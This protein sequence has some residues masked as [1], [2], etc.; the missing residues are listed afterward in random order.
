MNGSVLK[1]LTSRPAGAIP[2]NTEGDGIDDLGDF[3]WLRGIRDRALMLS[4][5]KKDGS[6]MAFGY[7]W[8]ERIEFDPTEGAT[9][10]FGN[11]TVK[12][13]GR[14]LNAEAR[15]SMRLIEGLSRHRVPWVKES[16]TAAARAAHNHATVIEELR[17]E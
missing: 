12:I 4:L 17:I 1:Q 15:P 16:D 13:I 11:Q 2:N 8:L 10:R 7:A 14:N 9:L 5:Y 6:V 3:G